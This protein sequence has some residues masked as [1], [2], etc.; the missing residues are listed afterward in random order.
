M[1]DSTFLNVS[2]LIG[3]LSRVSN[4]PGRTRNPARRIQVENIARILCHTEAFLRSISTYFESAPWVIVMER[5]V[6]TCS[7]WVLD[8]TSDWS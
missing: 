2:E 4:E 8:L 6:D 3:S 1:V 7:F 5:D